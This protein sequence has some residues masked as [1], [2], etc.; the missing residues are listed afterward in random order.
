M[1]MPMV[2]PSIVPSPTS[3]EPLVVLPMGLYPME[4]DITPLVAQVPLLLSG[5]GKQSEAVSMEVKNIPIL[6]DGAFIMEVI[7]S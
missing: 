3:V 7:A 2:V 1:A 6:L 4:E 5:D